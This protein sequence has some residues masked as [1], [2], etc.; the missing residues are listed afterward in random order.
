MSNKK[1]IMVILFM[2][3]ATVLLSG[4]NFQYGFRGTRELRKEDSEE[5]SLEKTK[6]D[7][8]SE[9]DVHTRMADIE[10]IPA[11]DFYVEIE[12]TYWEDEPE[13]TVENGK[14]VFDDW[15]CMPDSYSLR[16]SLNNY[17]KIYIPEETLLERIELDTA[18]GNVSAE[19]FISERLEIIISYGDLELTDASVFDADIRL[20]YGR[21]KIMDFNAGELEF[22]NSYGKADFTNINTGGLPLPEDSTYESINITMSS[23]N[24]TLTGVT[25]RT[26]DINDSYGDVTCEDV[27]SKELDVTLSNGDLEIIKADVA[28][29][30]VTDSYGD[31]T[32]SLLGSEEDYSLDLGYFLWRH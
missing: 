11:D 19:G 32:M 15:S 10:I 23:G 28:E 30:E 5:F 21:S 9:I 4:C 2:V 16:Y 20:S 26:I 27:I 31:V 13:Y 7:A 29:I 6:V 25:S 14:L 1:K 24:C 12:Y 22:N 3:M 17:I 18:S 8:I